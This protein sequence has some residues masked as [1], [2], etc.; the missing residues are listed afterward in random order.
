MPWVNPTVIAS[1]RDGDIRPCIDMRRTNEAIIR[2]RHPIPTVD[3]AD[4]LSRL[5]KVDRT[6]QSEI[7]KVAEEHVRFVAINS[8][9]NRQTDRQ[10]DRKRLFDP[11]TMCSEYNGNIKP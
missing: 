8:T 7:S 3:E 11:S 2:E 4:P 1:K 9:T 6:Q 5:L 10:T